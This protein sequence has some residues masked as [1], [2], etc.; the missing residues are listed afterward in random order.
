ML[1]WRSRTSPPRSTNKDGMVESP[2]GRTSASAR[3]TTRGGNAAS[4]TGKRKRECDVSE[5]LKRV[6]ITVTPGEL[7]LRN[8]VAQCRA[9]G[10]A[11]A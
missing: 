5:E 6:R 8:D 1:R 7:R 11:A 10:A 9:L 4:S 2:P 3:S